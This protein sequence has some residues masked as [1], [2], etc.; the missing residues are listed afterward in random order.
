MVALDACHFNHRWYWPELM[1]WMTRDP[2]EYEGGENLYGYVN[3]DPVGY[4]DPEGLD[5]RRGGRGPLG[6][7]N[8][9]ASE[10]GTSNPFK[11]MK[12][13][14]TD[15]TKVIVKDPNGKKI[16][17]PKPPGFPS[18]ETGRVRVRPL[19][20]MCGVLTAF[21]VGYWVGESVNAIPVGD[22]GMTTSEWWT[23]WISETYGQ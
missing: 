1:R 13:H 4:A 10:T 12:P 9:A 21:E 22:T 20:R 17:K 8:R 6:E 23:T 14:P 5:R 16:I 15:P 3:G 2:I 7:R 18:G 11:H 19:S